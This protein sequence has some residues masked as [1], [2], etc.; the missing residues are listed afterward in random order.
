MDYSSF[1]TLVKELEKINFTLKIV[2]L[3]FKYINYTSCKIIILFFISLIG[4]SVLVGI[5]QKI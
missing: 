1:R 4:I 2:F 3:D 5:F